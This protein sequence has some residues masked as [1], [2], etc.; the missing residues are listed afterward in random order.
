MVEITERKVSVQ[1]GSKNWADTQEKWEESGSL[2]PCL[3]EKFCQYYTLYNVGKQPFAIY[4]E[5]IFTIHF[6]TKK[7]ALI[8]ESSFKKL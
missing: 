5:G 8:L 1:Q 2:G 4:D 6:R 3:Q 7:E